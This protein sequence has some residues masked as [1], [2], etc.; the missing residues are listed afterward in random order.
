M[1][2]VGFL[3]HGET[4]A[5]DALI[6]R[7]DPHLTQKGRET[8]ARQLGGRRWPVVI[9]SPLMRARETAE[10]AARASAATIEID[11]AWREIDFGDWDGLGRDA[12]AGDARLAAFY[13]DPTAN[14]PPGGET[15]ADVHMRVAAALDRLAQREGP[16]LVAA[17]GGSIRMALSILLGLPLAKLWFIRIRQGTRVGVEIGRDATHGLWGELIE[18]A[19][20]EDDAP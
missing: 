1:T 15:M 7:T 6:G 18:I 2:R 16:I 5:G 20:P 4:E 12:L 13:A 19:Q 17:H 14:P 3:R 9:A 10:I 8:V 11:P